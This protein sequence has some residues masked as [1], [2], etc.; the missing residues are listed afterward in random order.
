MQPRKGRIVT[1]TS[2]CVCE[3]VQDIVECEGFVW[4][5]RFAREVDA[6]D[7][8]VAELCETGRGS[9]HLGGERRCIRAPSAFAP[10]AGSASTGRMASGGAVRGANVRGRAC[11]AT[12]QGPGA[13]GFQGGPL[14]QPAQSLHEEQSQ[15]VI[16][17]AQLCVCVAMCVRPC[18]CGHCPIPDEIRS[19]PSSGLVRTELVGP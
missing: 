18:V 14:A 15:E 4:R 5:S 9:P 6:G 12:A 8:P 1:K 7:G 13:Q 10:V 17:L 3:C 19:T 11:A 2:A 16:L